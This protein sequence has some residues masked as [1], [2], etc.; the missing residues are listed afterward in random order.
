L[1]V[2][3]QNFN[4]YAA[5]VLAIAVALGEKEE[6]D[7]EKEGNERKGEIEREE[8]KKKIVSLMMLRKLIIHLGFLSLL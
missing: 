7:E 5:C 8:T 1:F 4:S 2:R 3:R 6:E